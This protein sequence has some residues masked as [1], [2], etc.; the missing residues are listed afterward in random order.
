MTL[1]IQIIS[2]IFSFIY[3][4]FVYK[5]YL[6]IYKYLYNVKPIYCFLNNLLF[7]LIIT[8]IYFKIFYYINNANINLYF[9]I[10]TTLVFIYLINNKFTKKL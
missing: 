7:M 1:K 2:F 5:I 6:L 3:G 8:L 4:I 10:I 9:I